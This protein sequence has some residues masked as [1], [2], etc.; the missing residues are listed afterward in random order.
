[1]DFFS[2]VGRRGIGARDEKKDNEEEGAM[3]GDSTGISIMA[4]GPTFVKS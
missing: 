4:S 1:M 2:T 3:P